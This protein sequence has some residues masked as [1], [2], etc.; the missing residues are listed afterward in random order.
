MIRLF[1]GADT[2]RWKGALPDDMDW[3]FLDLQ[4]G[5][6]FNMH[7]VNVWSYVCSL[8]RSG[9]VKAI[10]GGPPCRTTSRLRCK[11]PPAPR[12]VRGRGSDRWGLEGLTA[13]ERE[14]VRGDSALVVQQVGLWHLRM[15][16]VKEHFFWNLRTEAGQEHPSF[17]EWPLLKRMVEEYG[18]SMAS[19]D[20]GRTGHSRRKPTSLLTNLRHLE[21]LDG[22]REE[23]RRT[24]GHDGRMVW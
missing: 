20:Q 14:Q 2:G 18:M 19:F 5:D 7:N 11:G 12:R 10:V 6:G 21:D 3:I 1:S 23:D 24:R 8:A 4:L 13:R 17:F 9:R 15:N 16:I 22:L